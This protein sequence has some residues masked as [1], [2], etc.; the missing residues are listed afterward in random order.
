[1][2]RPYAIEK[3]QQRGIDFIPDPA[4]LALVRRGDSKG[5]VVAAIKEGTPRTERAASPQRQKAYSILADLPRMSH[6][7]SL[8]EKYQSAIDLAPNS[9]AL[10]L[11]F[12][13]Y[14]LLQGKYAAAEAQ[15]RQSLELWPGDAD[16]HTHLAVALT[17]QF[18]DDEAIPEAREALRICPGHHGALMELGMALARDK[19]FQEAV[20]VLREAIEKMPT[21]KALHRHLGLSLFNTGD[22][23]GSIREYV[24]YLQAEPGDAEGHYELGVAFRAQGHKEDAQA[25]FRECARLDPSMLICATAADPAASDK[26]PGTSAARRPDD[27]AVDRNIYTN[28]FFGFS[29]QFPENWSVLSADD[30]RAAAKLGGGLISGG[31]ATLEDAQRAGAAHAYP[32]LFVTPPRGQGISSR[33]IQIQALDSQITPEIASAKDFLESSAKLYRRLHTPLQP[34][35]SAIEVSIDGRKLWRLDLIMQVD[36]SAHY[37]SEIVTI[38]NGF[39]LLF[40]LSSPDQSGLDELLQ[41]M[42]SLHFFGDASSQLP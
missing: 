3:I 9:P 33:S 26:A 8:S 20:P 40:A 15:A 10:H 37:L 18:R 11:A 30:A 12:A 25:Q 22:I 34:V 36:N 35:G 41:C 17:G 42:N 16:G 21:I 7:P 1:M 23:E 38:Q 27:G 4:F 14:L 5:D 2:Y 13:G 29:F 31:D 32:L 6:D 28:R 39:L 19:R 24:T